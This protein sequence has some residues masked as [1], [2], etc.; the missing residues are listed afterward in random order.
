MSSMSF[1]SSKVG[2]EIDRPSL[3]GHTPYDRNDIND[4]TGREASEADSAY[5]IGAESGCDDGTGER[6]PGLPAVLVRQP[7]VLP[8]RLEPRAV[9]WPCAIAVR[10]DCA[11]PGAGHVN[12]EGRRPPI[13]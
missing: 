8:Q 10:L 9:A 4:V 2:R 11:S 12:L 5:L 7:N 3:Y 1:M 13:G 6:G